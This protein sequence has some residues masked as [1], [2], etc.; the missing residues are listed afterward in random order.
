MRGAVH[1]VG[2][3]PG[4]ADLITLRGASRIAEADLVLYTPAVIEPAWLRQHTKDGADLV[5][6]GRLGAEEVV[7]LYRKVASRRHQA[8]RLF[9]GDAAHA[10]DVREHRELCEKVGL[11]V[12]IVPGIAPASAAAAATGNALTENGVAETAVFTE[13]DFAKVRALVTRCATV[14]V[15]APAARAAEL[16]ETLIAGGVD[17][18]MPVTVAYKIT[19][20]D[21]VL[22]RTTIG[23]LAAEVKRHNLW[24]HTLFLIGDALRES[25]PRAGYVKADGEAPA[26]RWSSRSWRR[27]PAEPRSPSAWSSRTNGTKVRTCVEPEVEEPDVKAPGIEAPAVPALN[28]SAPKLAEI[29]PAELNGKAVLNGSS[30]GSVKVAWPAVAEIEPPVTNGKPV[31][32]PAEQVKDDQPTQSVAKP[33]AR[34]PAKK[35]GHTPRTAARRTTKKS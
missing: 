3:G 9:A 31:E 13:A 6:L 20:P 30:N 24:R 32:L 11:D 35:G 19:S 18:D 15:Q 5:D 12:E 25:K 10:P 27:D 29:A 33:A 34:T 1:F 2:A 8:V 17:P 26:P 16:A 14:A 7:E 23:E 21:Q 22:A 28:G 4:A